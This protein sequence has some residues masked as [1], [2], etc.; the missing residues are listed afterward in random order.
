MRIP[1]GW[2]IAVI[3]GLFVAS[4]VMLLWSNLAV[5][6]MP[7]RQ[8]QTQQKLTE[9]SHRMADEAA[10]LLSVLP[11]PSPS[12]PP[13][14]WPRRLTEITARIL[15]DYPGVE[16]GFYLAG[17]WGR[18]TAHAFPNDPHP[19]PKAPTPPQGEPPPTTDPPPREKPFIAA[20]CQASLEHG[21]GQTIAQ[22][23]NIPPSRIL[24]VTEPVGSRRP[25]LVAT[26]TMTRLIS[27]EQTLED[28]HRYQTAVG[29]ALGG[30]VVS[31]ILTITLGRNLRAER[32]QQEKLRAELRRAEHLASLG[33]MLAGV[34]HEV[35]NPLAA[36]R[37]TVQLYQRLPPASRD[38]SAL[39][40]ILNGV[41]RLNALV[42]RL[43]YFARSAHEARHTVD[44]NAVVQETLSLIRA[45]AETQGVTLQTELATDLPSVS[46]SMQALGQVVLNLTI[47]ALQAMPKGGTLRCRTRRLEGSPCVELWIADTG[48][49]I[50]TEELPHLFE[51][52]HTTRPEGTGL[53][54]ALCRE[55]VQQHGGQI[56]FDRLADW[57]AV[58]RV[59][60]PV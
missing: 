24:V 11:S 12:E 59:T 1:I 14:D 10:A 51:P 2:Q 21:P 41:D 40:T 60:L 5:L 57:G 8:A 38:P 22:V 7:A 6:L 27:P 30:I 52:F 58:F 3:V 32:T 15:A 20:Q 28:L 13:T 47:N 31:L 35:R 19:P 55:I 44:L 54:L 42:S 43:L 45:Q 53:G 39:E 29:L 23:T 18:F 16:G 26:W 36:I 25:A 49:G 56:E 33:K 4:L 46:A 37:S 50:A 34:A 48:P 17:P 9:A